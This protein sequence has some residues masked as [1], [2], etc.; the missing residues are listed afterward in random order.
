MTRERGHL[1]ERGYVALHTDYRNH[2]GSDVVSAVQALRRSTT[3]GASSSATG[4]RR[5]LA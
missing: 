4:T 3:S 1:A 5:E 2:A